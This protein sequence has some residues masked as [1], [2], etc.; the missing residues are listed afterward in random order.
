LKYESINGIVYQHAQNNNF[1]E[2]IESEDSSPFFSK[3][4]CKLNQKLFVNCDY[5]NLQVHKSLNFDK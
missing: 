1:K 3:N 5:N 2:N 4:E